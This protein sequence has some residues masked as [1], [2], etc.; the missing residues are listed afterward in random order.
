MAYRLLY[1][2]SD[3]HN[4]VWYYRCL[5][6]MQQMNH[7]CP[8][9]WD[10][11]I[12]QTIT[13]TEYD[14]LKQFNIIIVHNGTFSGDTQ[15]KFWEFLV[16]AKEQG[17]KTV[18]DVDD[19]WDYGKDHPLY[20]YCLTNAIPFKVSGTIKLVDAVTTTTERFANLIRQLN[21][22]V[23]VVPNALC[24]DDKQFTTKKRLTDRVKFGLAGG[25]S[26]TNDLKEL[27]NNSDSFLNYLTNNQLDQMQIVLCGFDM[28][29]KINIVDENGKVVER[30]DM[31]TEDIWWVKLEKLLT[32]DYTTVSKEYA[33]LLKK[34]DGSDK[35][36]DASSEPYRRIWTTSIDKGEY[37]KIYEDIDVLMVPLKKTEFNSY[38]SELKFIEAGWTSTAIMASNVA[39]YSDWGR[40]NEDCMLV[41]SGPKN[42]ARAIKK[43]LRERQAVEHMADRLRSRVKAERDLNE[44]SKARSEVYLKI[45][46]V[47]HNRHAHSV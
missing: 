8:G 27:V 38:K 9:Q 4:G 6:P 20:S 15:D 5:R 43:A 16:W 13:W 25:S 31:P 22:N 36:Y 40:D 39:P 10:I 3:T 7:V 26:H 12:N 37:G 21:E 29:G 42:W 23:Y 46:E 30:R 32:K 28:R 41:G 19:Y 45:I 11:T 2:P 35:A 24:F 14:Y 17:I 33:E 1:V 44:I 47:V 34:Y 18:L